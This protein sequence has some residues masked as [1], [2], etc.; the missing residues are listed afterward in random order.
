MVSGASW[1]SSRGSLITRS[2]V[3]T[4][5]FAK[6][7]F[8]FPAPT[9]FCPRALSLAG[10]GK[11]F[12]HAFQARRIWRQRIATPFYSLVPP[13]SGKSG[14]LSLPSS[15]CYGWKYFTKACISSTSEDQQN[16]NIW[17]GSFPPPCLLFC[18]FSSLSVILG[19]QM[20]LVTEEDGLAH[21]KFLATLTRHQSVGSY[22]W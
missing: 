11:G 20:F 17:K 16:C 15:Y 3:W 12:L 4:Y 14:C 18:A 9:P 22:F 2:G 21:S 7:A 6:T 19:D 1:W 13:V 10:A 5:Q 8:P